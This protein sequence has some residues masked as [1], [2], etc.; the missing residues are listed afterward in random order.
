MSSR[1][2]FYETGFPAL[3]EIEPIRLSDP[4]GYFERVFCK[5]EFQAIGFTKDIVQINHTLTRHKGSIRGLHFQ[6]PP[7][8]ETKIV[9]CLQGTVFDVVVDL[10]AQS[11]TFL[12]WYG[13]I[14]SADNGKMLLIP[15][16]CAHGFQTLEDEVELFYLHTEFYH[17]DHEG[18]LRFDD[19]RLHIAWKLTPTDISERDRTHQLL[20]AHFTGITL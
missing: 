17:A 5:E 20:D 13:D 19:P 11:P 15:E 4:R 18:G 9:R 3:Y 14:L 2:H 8:A 12:Q 16:G 6:Y 7:Y 10:R 1:F